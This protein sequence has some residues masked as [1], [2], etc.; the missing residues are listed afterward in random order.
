MFYKMDKILAIEEQF[1]D[2]LR[3]IVRINNSCNFL[4]FNSQFVSLVR[5]NIV[6]DPPHS[7]HLERY[8]GKC[9]ACHKCTLC[10][11]V[12]GQGPG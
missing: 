7:K 9:R 8:S 2:K 5:F 6:S 3:A 1:L 12:A 11:Q 10:H 4:N